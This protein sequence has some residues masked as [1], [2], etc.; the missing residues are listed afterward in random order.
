MLKHSITDR[1]GVQWVKVSR[2][3]AKRAYELT[4]TVLMQPWMLDELDYDLCVRANKLN[5]T[6]K[7]FDA[8]SHHATMNCGYGV[9]YYLSYYVRSN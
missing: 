4:N 7:S 1:N 9:G 8:V 3:K 5:D 2:L 6:T